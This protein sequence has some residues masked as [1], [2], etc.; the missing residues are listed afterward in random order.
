VLPVQYGF[1]SAGSQMAAAEERCLRNLQSSRRHDRP[2]LRGEGANRFVALEDV[3]PALRSA[4]KL[5]QV[6]R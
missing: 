5:G 1:G 2:V 4:V 6:F 3:V